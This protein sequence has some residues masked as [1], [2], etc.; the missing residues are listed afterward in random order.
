MLRLSLFS[1]IWGCATFWGCLLYFYFPEI[2]LPSHIITKQPKENVLHYLIWDF[3]SCLFSLSAFKQNLYL[4]YVKVESK[5][6]L[7]KIDEVSYIAYITNASIIGI[8]ETKLGE[9]IL[10]SELEVNG[11]GLVRLN[12]SRRGGGVASYV[13]SSIAYS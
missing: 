8:S 1:G 2:D 11:Y 13:K 3:F 10:S 7:P 6:F 4:I 9:T 12:R 5:T